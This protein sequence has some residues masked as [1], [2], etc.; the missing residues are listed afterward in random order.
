MRAFINTETFQLKTYYIRRLSFADGKSR[1]RPA[2]PFKNWTDKPKIS[3]QNVRS[4]VGK[5]KK[6]RHERAQAVQYCYLP[7]S[8]ERNLKA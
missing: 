7:S 1:I 4:V 6:Y 3:F 8:A 5:L 2:G